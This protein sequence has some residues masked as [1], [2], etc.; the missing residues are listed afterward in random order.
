ML[1][2][3]DGG[4][5]SVK[6]KQPPQVAVL[7][8]FTYSKSKSST[9]KRTAANTLHYEM[10]EGGWGGGGEDRGGWGVVAESLSICL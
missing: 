1:G 8:L 7:T 4:V 9:V 2:E 6:M 5:E 10:P 3:G